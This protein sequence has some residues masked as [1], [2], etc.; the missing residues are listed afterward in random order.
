MGE[1]YAGGNGKQVSIIELFNLNYA[2]IPFG[3]IGKLFSDLPVAFIIAL[4]IAGAMPMIAASPAPAD[5]RSFRSIN[6]ISIFGI[7]LKRGTR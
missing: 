7:S 5:G 3:N 1:S 4:R 2:N 6:T